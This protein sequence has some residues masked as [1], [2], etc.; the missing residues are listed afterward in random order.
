VIE[1]Y[2]DVQTYAAAVSGYPNQKAEIAS[3]LYWIQY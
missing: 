1:C 3:R 2:P